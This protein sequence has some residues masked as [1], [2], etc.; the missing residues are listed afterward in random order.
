MTRMANLWLKIKVWTKISVAGIVALYLLIFILKNG[1]R[2]AEF[3]YWFGERGE[4]KGSLLSLVAFAFLIGGLV[5]ILATTTFRTIRQIKELRARNRSAKLEN[6]VADM[7]AKAAMLQTK[8]SM[9][10]GNSGVMEV[11]SPAQT[12]PS[13]VLLNDAAPSA[14]EDAAE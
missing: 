1:D 2:K 11:P 3:W 14:G 13:K 7:R 4:Y 5:T 8:P 10:S 9:R 12:D 6:E